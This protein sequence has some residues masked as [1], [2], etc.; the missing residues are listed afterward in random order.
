MTRSTPE[1]IGRD[2][3]EPAPQRVRVRQFERDGGRCRSC[4]VT[5]RAG[6]AWQC[7]HIVALANG[8]ANREQN[9]QT[10]CGPCH[11]LKTASDVAEKAISYRKRSKHIGA[12][13]SKRPMMG[14]RLSPW[15]HTMNGDW[16]R[17]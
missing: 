2:D 11:G 10:L 6:M 3:D 4:G 17:R 9:L 8:G 7:D 13:R 16:V 1:W 15:K 5:I 12:A 14:S